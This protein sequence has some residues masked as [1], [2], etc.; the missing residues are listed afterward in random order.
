MTSGDIWVARCAEIRGRWHPAPR[1]TVSHPS[2]LLILASL[3]PSLEDILLFQSIRA[4]DCARSRPRREILRDCLNG[5]AYVSSF[6]SSESLVFSAM[7]HSRLSKE[8]KELTYAAERLQDRRGHR[9]PTPFAC[10]DPACSQHFSRSLALQKHVRDT[11]APPVVAEVVVPA[12]E[13]IQAP[14]PPARLQ[15]QAEPAPPARL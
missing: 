12:A 8:E 15:A 6:S 5:L 11:H 1:L 13:G 9:R 10:P 3:L 4:G 2:I 7:S 14:P